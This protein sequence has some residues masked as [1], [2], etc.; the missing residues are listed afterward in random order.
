MLKARQDYV[1]DKTPSVF[2]AKIIISCLKLF[3]KQRGF[4]WPQ[5][6][7]WEPLHAL[8]PFSSLACYFG[9]FS[10]A[11]IKQALDG[12]GPLIHTS[13]W[14]GNEECSLSTLLAWASSSNAV[15]LQMPALIRRFWLCQQ[16][17]EKQDESLEA[18]NCISL[19]FSVSIFN[20][21]QIF[22]YLLHLILVPLVSVVQY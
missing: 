11:H 22:S 19:F 4:Q 2:V 13:V 14:I 9:H 17:W 15:T 21:C 12:C 10:K 6:A 3:A 20:F 18:K 1:Y 16:T 7:N 5:Q 8:A